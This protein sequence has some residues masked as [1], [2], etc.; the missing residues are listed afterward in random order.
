ML[1]SICLDVVNDRSMASNTPVSVQRLLIRVN[2]NMA[3]LIR[4]SYVPID[5]SSLVTHNLEGGQ[6]SPYLTVV[7]SNEKAPR[8]HRCDC[9]F[10][11]TSTSALGC[12]TAGERLNL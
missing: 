3:P 4:L 2:M 5:E 10:G 1:E 6:V 11:C 9:S 12:F 7:S 8:L